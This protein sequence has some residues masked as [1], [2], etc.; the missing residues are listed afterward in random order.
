MIGNG[1]AVRLFLDR[2][3]QGED[4][5]NRCDR[6]FMS[7]RR[8]KRARSVAVIL[9]HTEGRNIQS[10][11]IQNLQNS[12]CVLDAAVDEQRVWPLVKARIAVYIM[13]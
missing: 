1:K 13:R 3:D 11:F 9:D 7:L 12:V 5:R 2:S 4:R 8:D 6:N 10:Q